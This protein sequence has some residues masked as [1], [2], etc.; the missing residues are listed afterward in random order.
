MVVLRESWDAASYA[1]LGLHLGLRALFS[2]QMASVV[3]GLLPDTSPAVH[4]ALAACLGALVASWIF[5]DQISSPDLAWLLALMSW[6]FFFEF[7]D[8]SIPPRILSGLCAG[9]AFTLTE[10]TIILSVPLLILNVI[11]NLKKDNGVRIAAAQWELGL[12]LGIIPLLL[13]KFTPPTISP[14]P[15]R[16][17]AYINTSNITLQELPLIIWPFCLLGVVVSFFQARKAF[18]ALL[19][20]FFVL[21]PVAVWVFQSA[22]LSPIWLIP[23]SVW[24]SYG[25]YRLAKGIEQGVRNANPK[26]AGK[27]M[28]GALFAVLLAYAVWAGL[29]VYLFL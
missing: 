23:V 26:E 17:Q 2:L 27:V 21:L 14:D 13:G 19:L 1:T 28:G 12:L 18:L 25:L 9:T 6:N 11:K 22:S 10:E 29:S 24:T 16:L 3:R 8:R 7:D 20:P 15:E 5:T 4:K